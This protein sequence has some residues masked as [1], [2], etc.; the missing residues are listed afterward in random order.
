MSLAA[1][2]TFS[3]I[4]GALPP[5]ITLD[6]DGF[7][8]GSA[9]TPGPYVFTVQATGS[10]GQSTT[11]AYAISV[12]GI[13]QVLLTPAQSNQP[14]FEQLT[15]TGMGGAVTWA[16]TDGFLPD[17][18]TLSSAG[19]LEGEATEDGDFPIE[20]TITN[21]TEVCH[22]DFV[23]TVEGPTFCDDMVW[24]APVITP[25]APVA[26]TGS[27]TASECEFH[28]EATAPGFPDSAAGN[29]VV[30]ITGQQFYTGPAI[31]M[32]LH[33]VVSGASGNLANSSIEIRL[34]GN[35]LLL[36]FAPDLETNGTYDYP[37]TIPISVAADFTVHPLMI[38]NGSAG[39]VAGV[40]DGTLSVVP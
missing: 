29:Q 33:L 36:I 23:L 30:D 12:A 35:P 8:S 5:G 37:F 28:L 4:A 24:G 39:P 13:D 17:G 18:I 1:P 34:D 10:D 26:G 38:A 32:N 11:R 14:Y 9:T 20:I 19:L 40:W 27:A 6:Q 15:Q 31:N 3:V 22:R 21:G 25:S 16:L 7:I 2:V